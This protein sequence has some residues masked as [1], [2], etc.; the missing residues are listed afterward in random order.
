MCHSFSFNV[1]TSRHVVY[2]ELHPPCGGKC[3]TENRYLFMLLLWTFLWDIRLR[4][5]FKFLTMIRLT[6]KCNT[7]INQCS[8]LVSMEITYAHFFPALQY[9]SF[10]IF[11]HDGLSTKTRCYQIS[12]TFLSLINTVTLLNLSSTWKTAEVIILYVYRLTFELIMC[13]YSAG[14]GN[15]LFCFVVVISCTF[16]IFWTKSLSFVLF[17]EEFLFRLFL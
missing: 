8:F 15:V 14:V 17:G 2:T 4:M 11:T 16:V 9:F 10:I 3:R 13:L 6:W 12:I 5:P 1:A 7:S